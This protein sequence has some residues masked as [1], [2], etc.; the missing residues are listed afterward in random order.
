MTVCWEHTVKRAEPTVI[1]LEVKNARAIAE[2]VKCNKIKL[3]RKREVPEE[4]S[5]GRLAW[6]LTKYSTAFRTD[7]GDVGWAALVEHTIPVMEE[8]WL[9]RLPPH[10]LEL[11]KEAE[12]EQVQDL[13]KKGII[14]PAGG[15]W[16]SPVVL[17]NKED[18]KWHFRVSS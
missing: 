2:I 16:S 1:Q 17:V 8:I 12:V 3:P 15:A 5:P 10:Q 4:R 6:L 13:V 18:G 7:D 14:K 9:R 11:E